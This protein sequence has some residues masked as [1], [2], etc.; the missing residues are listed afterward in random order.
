MV[1]DELRI[2]AE[3]A[4]RKEHTLNCPLQRIRLLA[5]ARG[6]WKAEWVD[7][8]PGLID[9]AAPKQIVATW[10]DRESFLLD[11]AS[12]ARLMEYNRSLGYK[13]ESPVYLAIET[14]L[15]SIGE[16]MTFHKGILSSSLEAMTRVM[17]RAGFAQNELKLPAYKDRKDNVHLPFDQALEIGQSFCRAEPS[18]V[19]TV[20]ESTER[21]WS[22]EASRPG[23]EY[24]IPL[25]NSHRPAWALLRQWC[26]N[27]AS[28]ATQ[29]KQINT[30][31][32]L[33]EDAVHE[34]Q[35]AGAGD[36]AVRIRHV[37]EHGRNSCSCVLS[38]MC[39][40]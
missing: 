6:K 1:K 16:Y 12:W 13:A 9:C 4:F 33:L 14:L 22:S 31:V 36:E 28:T 7:P 24:I 11:E 25:L 32:H 38:Q 35:K 15:D 27:D 40:T 8:N 3:Y 23:E 17:E 19:L 10:E 26:C 20:V 5:W 34:L 39:R 21:E 37:L 29:E 18:S 2:G 30:L